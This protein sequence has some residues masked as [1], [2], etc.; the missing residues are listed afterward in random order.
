MSRSH[1]PRHSPAGL[2]AGAL[3]FASLGAGPQLSAEPLPLSPDFLPIE[4]PPNGAFGI[5]LYLQPNQFSGFVFEYVNQLGGLFSMHSENTGGSYQYLTCANSNPGPDHV[6]PAFPA[7]TLVDA[8][9]A[10][11][12]CFFASNPSQGRLLAADFGG[13]GG[14]IAVREDRFS[15]DRYGFLLARIDPDGT[16]QILSGAIE[17]QDDVPIETTPEPQTVFRDRFESLAASL[18]A[19]NTGDDS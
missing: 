13:A 14:F 18:E 9:L 4:V 3:L 7:G 8:S 12:P 5:G 2:L 19:P 15:G 17:S 16:L 10:S 11:G 1:P 6:I